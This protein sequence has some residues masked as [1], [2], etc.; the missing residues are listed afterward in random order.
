MIWVENVP[1]WCEFS[2]KHLWSKAKSNANLAVY[3]PDFANSRL[4]QRYLFKSSSYC[5]GNICLTLLILFRK[6]Q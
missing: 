1:N 2:A 3:F 6:T 5:L 4:P